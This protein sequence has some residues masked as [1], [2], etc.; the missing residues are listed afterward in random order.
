MYIRSGCNNYSRNVSS[1]GERQGRS[2]WLTN[3]IRMTLIACVTIVRP[4]RYTR[5]RF[6]NAGC[7]ESY[8]ATSDTAIYTLPTEQITASICY[9]NLLTFA[10]YQQSR[11]RWY[12]MVW[13]AHVML[14][15]RFAGNRSM[16]ITME[17]CQTILLLFIEIA[18]HLV[19]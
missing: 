19:Q 14:A 18:R 11:V 8:V 3:N 7:G 15:R 5:W 1:D 4:T 17:H 13:K 12:G 10:D 9:K 16:L 6:I 2:W